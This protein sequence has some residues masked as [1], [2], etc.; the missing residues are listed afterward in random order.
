VICPVATNCA[1]S[2]KP[3][4]VFSKE[5]LAGGDCRSAL[6]LVEAMPK[7]AEPKSLRFYPGLKPLGYYRTSP[8]GLEG[9]FAMA[10]CLSELNVGS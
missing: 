4:D 5:R 6:S 9:T 1:G 7:R 3:V 10:V 8:P 2:I